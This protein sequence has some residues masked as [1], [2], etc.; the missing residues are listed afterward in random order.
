MPAQK[1]GKCC[2]SLLSRPASIGPLLCPLWCQVT[3]PAI[4]SPNPAREHL[5]FLG[6]G[7]TG[8]RRETKP[9]F[10]SGTG[11]RGLCGWQRD[12]HYVPHTDPSQGLAHS[13][14]LLHHSHGIAGRIRLLHWELNTE[15]DEGLLRKDWK[16][17]PGFHSQ[18]R[19]ILCTQP[20]LWG[21]W[22]LW[23]SEQYAKPEFRGA[24]Q[25]F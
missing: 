19:V 5:Q 9:S 13:R 22:G 1:A 18:A 10:S 21:L 7:G 23:G 4:L 25:T 15:S 6:G 24:E 20:G 17:S 12:T 2:L 16:T 14:C 11:L 8:W 3:A